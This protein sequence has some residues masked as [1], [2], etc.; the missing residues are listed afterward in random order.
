MSGQSQMLHYLRTALNESVTLFNLFGHQ[1]IRKNSL[2]EIAKELLVE[3]ETIEFETIDL[4]KHEF[5]SWITA[6]AHKD[7]IDYFILYNSNLDEQEGKHALAHEVGHLA[8]HKK[9]ILDMSVSDVKLVYEEQA[10]LF[11][12]LTFWPLYMIFKE[13]GKPR[14]EAEIRKDLLN[15]TQS[16]FKERNF[17]MKNINDRNKINRFIHGLKKH[18]PDIYKPIC[19]GVSFEF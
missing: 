16:Y 2:S 9:D 15:Y 13:T 10:D 4:P 3:G 14:S 12:L 8:L 5:E 1:T 6:L 11:A 18:L 17:D 19:D 7:G